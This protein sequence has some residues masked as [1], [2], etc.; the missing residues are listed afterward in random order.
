MGFFF[1]L[2]QVEF[3]TF[4]PRIF[5]VTPRRDEIG[6]IWDPCFTCPLFGDPLGKGD[7]TEMGTG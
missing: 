3:A 7:Q 1:F 6:R 4:H 5:P 2:L